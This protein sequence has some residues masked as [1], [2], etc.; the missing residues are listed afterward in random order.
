MKDSE[1]EAENLNKI[2]LK[3]CSKSTKMAIRVA[4]VNI[5]KKFPGE[6]VPGPP[7]RFCS[8][9]CFKVTLREKAFLKNVEIKIWSPP[10]NKDSEYAPVIKHH[11]RTYLRLFPGL[12]VFVSGLH[13]T[14]LKLHPP[15]RNFI[16]PL[17][18]TTT[19][20]V[21]T[22]KLNDLYFTGIF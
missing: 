18:R 14:F 15:H 5:F 11:Q 9:I 8:S 20:V 10:H 17:L 13:S 3:N 21:D 16:D 1:L 19:T 4:Y 6:H 22:K 2:C 12:N 7:E